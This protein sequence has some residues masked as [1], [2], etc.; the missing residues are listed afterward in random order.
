[1]LEYCDDF[2]KIIRGNERLQV[3]RLCLS[4]Q[5]ALAHGDIADFLSLLNLLGSRDLVVR[6]LLVVA[7]DLLAKLLDSHVGIS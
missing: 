4:D 6:M 5:R 2:K 7:G 3:V 1:M